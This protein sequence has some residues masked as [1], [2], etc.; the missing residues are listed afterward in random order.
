MNEEKGAFIKTKWKWAGS[1]VCGMSVKVLC[2]SGE[3]KN[4]YAKY[5]SIH[6]NTALRNGAGK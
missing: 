3:R 6:Q 2:F 4:V 1:E 5:L